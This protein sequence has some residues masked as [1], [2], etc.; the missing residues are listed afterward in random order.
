[1][2]FCKYDDVRQDIQL[3][4]VSTTILFVVVGALGTAIMLALLWGLW[5]GLPALIGTSFGPFIGGISLGA[6]IVGFVLQSEFNRLAA[7]LVERLE[8]EHDHTMDAIDALEELERRVGSASLDNLFPNGSPSRRL[9]EKRL[10][11]TS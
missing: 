3:G 7:E 2:E 6:V 9:H 4:R 8:R 10:G 11:G 5:M 1:M